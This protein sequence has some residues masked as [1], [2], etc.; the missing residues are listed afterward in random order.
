LTV[1]AV[2]DDLSLSVPF[3][4]RRA[5]PPGVTSGF[6]VTKPL[7]V[8]G[9]LYVLTYG[10]STGIVNAYSLDML[11]APAAGARFA[12]GSL[13]NEGLTQ[14][15]QAALFFEINS[16]NDN[17]TLYEKSRVGQQVELAPHRGLDPAAGSRPTKR[18]HGDEIGDRLCH[19]PVPR[20]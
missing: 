3:E 2:A 16:T 1:F 19:A 20:V 14:D 18:C 11:S 4:Y 15:G 7:A 6:D 9:S 8:N 5:R 12:T 10:S 17:K 13:R